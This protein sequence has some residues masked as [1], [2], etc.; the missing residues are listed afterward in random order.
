MGT[1]TMVLLAAAAMAACSGAGGAPGAARAAEGEAASRPAPGGDRPALLVVANKNEA[2]ASV[3]D[4]ASGRTL[5]RLR[6][7]TGPHEAAVS[8]D[9][10]W[11]VIADYGDVATVGRTLTVID[12]DALAVARTI[13]L[14]EYRR[15]HGIAFLPGDTVVAVTVEA[16]QAIAL[17]DFRTGAVTSIRTGENGTHM[18]GVPRDGRMVYTANMG[19]GTVTAIDLQTR[20]ARSARVAPRSEGIA[21][22]PDGSQVWVGSND[23][24]TVTVMDARTL[25]PIDTLPAPGMP[26]RLNVGADG[27]HVIVTNPMAN[28]VRVFD[29]ATRRELAAIEIPAEGGAL[30]PGARGSMPVGSVVTPD[31]RFVYV[32]LMGTNAVAEVDLGTFQVLRYFETG[33]GPDGIAYRPA[34]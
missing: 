15:P 27:R 30:V 25:T 24:H 11:A 6:T 17:V 14:G 26:Y 23:H 8:H 3:I 9:G 13:S 4:V 21:V 19:S 32:A 1:T 22:L 2:T 28:M 20:T 29:P 16:N 33:S 18:L 12:L 7:G 31:G 5:A 10:R 34:S